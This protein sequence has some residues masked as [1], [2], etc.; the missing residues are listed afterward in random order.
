MADSSSD[1]RGIKQ[2]IAMLA[3]CIVQ[4]MNE[5]N[6]SFQERFLERL[7]R[8]Y[9]EVKDNAERDV[10]QEMELLSWTRELL[11]GFNV[12]SGQGKPFLSE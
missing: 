10:L 1:L 6:P 2:G 11:T 8:A 12:I 3:A 9:R 4:T 7:G 5:S